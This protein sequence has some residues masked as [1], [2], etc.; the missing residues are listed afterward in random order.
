MTGTTGLLSIAGGKLTTFRRMAERVVDLACARLR[1]A[2]ETVAPRPPEGA[3]PVLSGGDTG[4]DLDAYAARLAARWPRIGSDVVG[5]LVQ[6]YGS[7][8]ERLVE[9]MSADPL[10]AER[11]HPTSAVTRA[12]VEYTVREEMALTLQD[13]LERRSRL[14]LWDADN[15][16][17]IAEGVARTMGMMMKWNAQRVADETARYR[18][19]VEEIKR[20]EPAAPPPS[21]TVPAAAHA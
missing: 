5:R 19:Q 21:E 17:T 14:L 18:A 12:E 1:E 3:E 16:L 4:D 11:Y 13:V 8:A 20:F 7:A 2:G 6:G 15:G 9:A 10:L